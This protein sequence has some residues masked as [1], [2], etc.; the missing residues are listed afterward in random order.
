MELH[1]SEPPQRAQHKLAMGLASG[2]AYCTAYCK[3]IRAFEIEHLKFAALRSWQPKPR[4]LMLLVLLV[5]K[6]IYM[7]SRCILRNLS[8]SVWKCRTY[9]GNNEIFSY[10]SPGPTTGFIS[11]VKKEEE[12]KTRPYSTIT[13]T[14]TSTR[15]A[16]YEYHEFRY[17]VHKAGFE[18]Y[19]LSIVLY[20]LKGFVVFQMDTVVAKCRTSKKPISR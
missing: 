9:Q 5:S 20:F 17:W 19:F 7:E 10:Y 14:R 18:P 1:C 12:R 13:S 3:S 6:A 2:T 11:P 16:G 4:L 8:N 15:V